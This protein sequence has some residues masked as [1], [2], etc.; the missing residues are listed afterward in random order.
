LESL[1]RLDYNTSRYGTI[2]GDMEAR[3][4]VRQRAKKQAKV[5]KAAT[6]QQISLR[7]K[8]SVMSA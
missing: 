5:R 8:P 7:P 1:S 4:R 3:Q 2:A 6:T